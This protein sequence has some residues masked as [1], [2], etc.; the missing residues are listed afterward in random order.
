MTPEERKEYN[1][2]WYINNK[3]KRDIQL[4]DYRDNNKEKIKKYHDNNKEKRKIYNKN[5]EIKI[6][7]NREKYNK[8]NKVKI[9]ETRK[10]Y[11]KKNKNKNDIYRYNYI[12]NRLTND[13]IFKLKLNIRNLIRQSFKIKNLIKNNK[14]QDILGSSFEE[15]KKYLESKFKPWMNWDNRGLYNGELNYGWDIDH[16]IPLS[17]A[18]TQ[19]DIL[20]LNHH[21]NLQ[22]LCSKINRDI[23]KGY[24]S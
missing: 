23:I 17:S 13:P 18:K 14:T 8:I 9:S 4:K 24:M 10:E 2:I 20:R 11:N 5:N 21:T 19:E 15:F 3:I 7:E 22:P 12:K 1:R 16:I 6:K